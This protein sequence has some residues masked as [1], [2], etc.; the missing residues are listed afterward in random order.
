MKL[1]RRVLELT[2]SATLQAK[3]DAEKVRREGIDVVDFGPGEPDF[4]TPEIIKEAAKRALDED[5]THYTETAGIAGLREA[6]A[7]RYRRDYGT[8]YR[9][10]EVFVGCG[11]K[12]V[13]YLIAQAAFN[14]GDRVAMFAPHWVSFPD[15][16]R[17]AGAEPVVLSTREEDDFIPRCA[18]LEAELRKA[19]IRA[20]ILNSPCN[21][22]GAALPADEL[23]RFAA[24]AARHDFLLISDET[25][26]FFYY[27]AG[28]FGSFAA[29]ASEVRGQLVL[30]SSFSKS[31][32]MTG[33]RVG[34]ALGPQPLI[35]AITKI[36]S[37]DATHTASF[38]MKGALAALDAPRS[39]LDSMREEYRRRR[40]LMVRGLREVEGIA[41][42]E[43]AGAFYV[44]PNVT[45]LM[46]RF[47]CRDSSRLARGLLLGPGIA[48]VAGSAF[49][50][51]GHLR[52][53]YATS[54]ERIRE[55]LRRLRECRELPAAATSE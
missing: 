2:S 42:R 45:G 9:A 36:Q 3:A 48:T 40:D 35:A 51:D 15:Q 4:H 7:G 31:Y 28:R 29:L 13:L 52:L 18:A 44:F 53:S 32:A 46:S 11:A 5:F 24:L 19:P 54:P 27:G 25:Y 38:S 16:V 33:W 6:L 55:G 43:P 8:D 12:N 34:Y 20:L 14:P 50:C 10:E 39:I 30:V 47:G 21:P 37:H 22:T 1:S 26:E 41:C 23:A 49:G 17:L